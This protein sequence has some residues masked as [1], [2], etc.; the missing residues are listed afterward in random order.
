MD[1]K[2]RFIDSLVDLRARYVDIPW[3]LGGNFDMIKSLLEKKGGT[4]TLNK[5]S[6]AFQTFM[7]SMKLVD[8]VSSNGLFTW[9]NKEEES[10]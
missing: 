2:L 5:D 8:I 6:L 10:L 4:K 9:N 3:I 1:D 7:D